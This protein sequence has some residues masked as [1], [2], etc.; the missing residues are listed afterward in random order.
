MK[1]I[2]ILSSSIAGLRRTPRFSFLLG[3]LLAL[4]APFSGALGATY[5]GTGAGFFG[6]KDYLW[7]N[8]NNWK[9]LAAPSP[10]EGNATLVFP[11]AVVP[12][13]TTND[14]PG[15]TVASL[16][17][18]G[19]DYGIYGKPAGIQLNLSAHGVNGFLV[20][21]SQDGNEIG[22]S[23]N[24]SL[25]GQGVFSVGKAT[26]FAL[27]CRMS[28][29]GGF[30]KKGQGTLTLQ[31]VVSNVYGGETVVEDGILQLQ[32]F[33]TPGNPAAI[34]VP[35]PLTIGDG[36]FSFAPRARFG[37]GDQIAKTAPVRVNA[38]GK[39]WLNTHDQT[40][41][42]LTLASGDVTTGL[43]GGKLLP[44]I[45]TLN[46]SVTNLFG[47]DADV[48]TISGLLSLGA[49]TRVFSVDPASELVI[50]ANIGGS[51][52]Q[53][54]GVLK[55]GDGVLTL[56]GGTNTY[57]GFTTVQKGTLRL[58]G[59]SP[60][61]G[62]SSSGTVV[63]QGAR[64]ELEG[65]DIAAEPLSLIG[66]AKTSV[67]Y[68]GTNSWGGSVTLTGDCVFEGD[69]TPQGAADELGLSGAIFGTGGLVKIGAGNLELLGLVQNSF[70]GDLNV[71]E[72]LV[73]L[74]KTSVSA[75]PGNLV[76]G[77]SPSGP[78][79]AL[80]L[81]NQPYQFDFA[82]GK[83]RVITVNP[84]GK[85]DCGGYYQTIDNLLLRDGLVSIGKGDLALLGGVQTEANSFGQSFVFGR[86]TLLYGN[87]GQH[88]FDVRD[89]AALWLNADVDEGGSDPGGITK[90]GTGAL[91]LL[92]SNTFTGKFY[93]MNG[94]VYAGAANAL[95]TT[96][97][98]TIVKSGATLA[99]SSLS[100]AEPLEL[101]GNGYTNAGA[102]R[103]SGTNQLSG[104]I[105]L[106]VDAKIDTVG[107]DA[108]LILTGVVEG[109]GGL[110]KHGE[111]RLRLG[112]NLNNSFTGTTR[113]R[114]GALELDKINA[115]AIRAVL[116]I[117]VGSGNGLVRY[118][119][120]FQ[121]HD[122]VP[123]NVG[124]N[125]QF[126]M[127]GNNDTIGSLS[128][129]GIVELLGATLITGNDGTASTYAGVISGVGGRVVKVG[130]GAFTLA[131]NN[132]YT[133]LTTVKS[134]TLFVRGQQPLSNV[135]ILSGGALAGEGAVG[136][137]SDQSGDIKP[138]TLFTG[139]LRTKSLTSALA[140]NRWEFKIAGTTP[141]SGHDQIEVDGD[142][143]IS[144]ATLKVSLLIGGAVGNQ[145]V[146]VK[147]NGSKQA[148]GHFAGLTDGSI[149][150]VNGLQF[151]ITYQGGDGNDIALIQQ[152][153]PAGAQLGLIQKLGDGSIEISGQG[154]PK[155]S[156]VVE[157]TESFTPPVVWTSLDVVVSEANG[158]LSFKD[159]EAPN[160][161]VR[162]YRFVQP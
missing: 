143:A 107:A 49:A 145:Y 94:T 101:A 51:P 118:L 108:L 19:A 142:V 66:S 129:Y 46:G 156:Y 99:L 80:V 15:L 111:G 114:E 2:D 135:E 4:A 88:T 31:S 150:T 103:V 149:V 124:A 52:V 6:N 73:I 147:N 93:A 17:F 23:V 154:Q 95:G 158:Q 132:V 50:D 130:A 78:P 121:L 92:G 128:G 139:I 72:G 29:A 109:S 97:G 14:V 68:R 62:G 134:G 96:D 120:P 116:E 91:A 16:S 77:V 84:T 60:L 86:L 110:S 42:N 140:A 12:K 65:V 127:L 59:N 141:G 119:K 105:T 55:T 157:A 13:N 79:P 40:I 146:L 5:T 24:L 98:A 35:G 90:L 76:V 8:P 54:P 152:T 26:T 104:K 38:N 106:S 41:G 47:G 57:G 123:V 33:P 64:L 71:Q 133:G 82:G 43:G 113:V 36:D 39:L 37:A 63:A 74:N 138:G 70:A 159:P 69:K 137:V 83:Q 125:G 160:H 75:V 131:G 25:G 34:A 21:A 11:N 27:G 9:E 162:F 56:A 3:A 126:R 20:A 144:G 122:L 67:R 53:N 87:N 45:L 85:L 48:S 136:E 148:Q 10:G 151:R 61:L 102:L 117:A 155:V 18:L 22:G 32:C 28:G 7:S 30:T 44:G 89:N 1:T 58:V 153:A 161:P 115:L 81:C 112:G 100:G